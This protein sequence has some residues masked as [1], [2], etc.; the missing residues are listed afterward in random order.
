MADVLTDVLTDCELSDLYLMAERDRL[1]YYS[2]ELLTLL[3][4]RATSE[5]V[6]IRTQ[7]VRAVDADLRRARE[8]AGAVCGSSAPVTDGWIGSG[9]PVLP[10]VTLG[11]CAMCGHA[12]RVVVPGA[13][14][15]RGQTEDY[16]YGTINGRLRRSVRDPFTFG[17]WSEWDQV[18]E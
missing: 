14:Y 7:A 9:A 11:S 1:R 3:V 8:S 5:L 4:Q 2:P 18:P 6:G 13:R 15:R 12:L 16:A 10:A 17:I